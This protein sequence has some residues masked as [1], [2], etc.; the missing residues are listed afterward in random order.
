MSTDYLEQLSFAYFLSKILVK[1]SRVHSP[2]S[3]FPF[4]H[5]LHH[6]YTE[7]YF[8]V[9]PFILRKKNYGSILEAVVIT[10]IQVAE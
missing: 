10:P 4:F 5:H 9:M 8:S 3:T 7:T 1:I 2:T 6:G